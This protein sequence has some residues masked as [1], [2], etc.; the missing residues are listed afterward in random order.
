M[1][2]KDHVC[3]SKKFLQQMGGGRQAIQVALGQ[4]GYSGIRVQNHVPPVKNV[5]HTFGMMQDMR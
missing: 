5:D 4:V 2:P 1:H 3:R